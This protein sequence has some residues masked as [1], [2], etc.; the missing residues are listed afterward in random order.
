MIG[1]PKHGWIGIDFGTKVAKVAQLERAGNRLVTHQITVERLENDGQVA[2]DGERLREALEICG[3]FRGRTVAC[4]LP[5]SA[6]DL[7]AMNVPPGTDAERRAMIAQELEAAY[8]DGT[9]REFDFW[10]TEASGADSVNVLSVARATVDSVT[11]TLAVAGLECA[12][13]DGLPCTLARAVAMST[14]DIAGPIAAIDWGYANATVSIVE[15]GRPQFTRPLRDCGAG[16]MFTDVAQA[17]G[18]NEAE[19]A[20]VL[21]RFGLPDPEKPDSDGD[22]IGEVVADI[23]GGQL[24]RVVDELTRTFSFLRLQRQALLPKRLLLFGAGAT[25]RNAAAFVAARLETPCDVWRLA[26]YESAEGQTTGEAVFGPATALS[27]LA[28]KP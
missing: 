20:E 9:A 8:S 15:H 21:T 25:V 10:E 2:G 27:A 11:A 16:A 13:L 23:I 1:K 5:M 26:N 18:L 19:A 17:L 3:Q 12:V 14:N 6:T 7:R 28:W 22:E 24:Q 4:T